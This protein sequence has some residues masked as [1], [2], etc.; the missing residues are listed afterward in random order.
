VSRRDQQRS[1]QSTQRIVFSAI[2]ALSAFLFVAGCGKKGPPLAPFV[3]LPLPPADLAAG[4]RGDAVDLSF[5]VPS[6]NTDGTRPANV[7]RADVYAITAPVTVPPL[8]D[9]DLLKYGT[10]VGSV[11]VKAPRDPNLTADAD[12]P[13]D[14][15]DAPEG[16]GLDQGAVARVAETLTADMESV[17]ELPRKKS[18]PKA[19]V[20]AADR[21]GPLLEPPPTV[22]S[23]MYVAFG[24]STRGRKGPLSRRVLVPL[25]PPPPPPS[26][27]A[28]T[29]DEKTV[30]LT[31]TS[32]AI[33]TAATSRAN[34]GLL[35]SRLLGETAVTDEWTPVAPPVAPPVLPSRLIG[36]MQPPITYNVY[37]TTIPTAAVRLTQTPLTDSRYSDPRIVW[38]EKRC[39]V[40]VAAQTVGGATI[41]SEAP[42]ATC[43]TLVDT[44][45]PASPKG[46]NAIA[47]EG[48]INLIWEPNAE[49]DL[50][51]YIVLRGVEPGQ[52]L[53][54]ITPAPIKEPSFKDTVK[55]G[56]AYVYAVRAVD[57]AGNASPPSEH[58][59]ETAR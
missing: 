42:P 58:V 50:E 2:A 32:A 27:P 44:F 18:A 15:V 23:R 21:G 25:V 6:V 8:S 14:E 43:E 11:E 48:A 39:Y 12:D 49:K 13:A 37:D 29:Y 16:R 26:A 22:R 36:L 52:T 10:K 24:T 19:P 38:G 51:G 30:T 45:P 47:S 34:D 1:T 4:R 33:W 35:P 46:I 53:E 57:K 5:T 20:A 3:K 55:P 40:V 31:W 56:I 7:A 17:V 9:A 28:M 54:P 59:V 41:E